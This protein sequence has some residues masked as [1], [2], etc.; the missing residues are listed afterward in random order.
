VDV[1]RLEDSGRFAADV[2]IVCSACQQPFQFLGLEAGCD[3]NGARVSMDG[4]EA[5]LA[6]CPQG[7]QPSPLNDM[8]LGFSVR[9]VM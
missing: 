6:I 3:L 4:L 9:K 8:A 7:E 5:R 1:I 2:R